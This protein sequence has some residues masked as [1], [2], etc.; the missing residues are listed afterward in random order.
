MN[1]YQA[2][3]ERAAELAALRAKGWTLAQLRAHAHA[4]GWST[5]TKERIRQVLAAYERRQREG[6]P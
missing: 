4:H 5:Y 6:Q 3:R 1:T 2:N